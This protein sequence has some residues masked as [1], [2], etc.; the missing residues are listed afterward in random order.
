LCL[1]GFGTFP[2]IRPMVH[3]IVADAVR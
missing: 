2:A 1:Q 3:S